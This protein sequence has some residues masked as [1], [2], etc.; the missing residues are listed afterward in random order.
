LKFKSKQEQKKRVMAYYK[1]HTVRCQAKL[2]HAKHHGHSDD[3][4]GDAHR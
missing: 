1:I 4:L 3:N 2:Y